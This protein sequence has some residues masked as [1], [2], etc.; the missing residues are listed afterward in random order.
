MNNGVVCPACGGM[1]TWK[2]GLVPQFGKRPRQ[3][4]ICMCGK[5]FYAPKVVKR[6]VVRATV[7]VKRV[8]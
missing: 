1:R 6:V 2:K 4:Y 7:P 5:T 3:R 8:K